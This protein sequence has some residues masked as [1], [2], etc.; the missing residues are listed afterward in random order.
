MC[1]NLRPEFLSAESQRPTAFPPSP[2]AYNHQPSNPNP[3]PGPSSALPYLPALPTGVVNEE[4]VNSLDRYPTYEQQAWANSLP[5]LAMQVYR[6]ILAKRS[7][8][9]SQGPPQ[10]ATLADLPSSGR[11]NGVPSFPDRLAPP[12][13]T[14]RCIDFSFS[15]VAQDPD[16]RQAIRLHNMRGVVTHAVVVGAETSEIEL[17]AYVADARKGES[18]SPGKLAE[19][20]FSRRVE[21]SAHWHAVDSQCPYKSGGDQDRGGRDEA[22]GSDGD[23]LDLYQ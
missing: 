5:P 1:S 18:V 20:C 9:A 21:R 4:V 23:E 7:S 6:Q 19:V 8:A 2:S 10:H 13:P 22:W 3:T 15:S 17:T 16:Y 12:L 14:I 11:P